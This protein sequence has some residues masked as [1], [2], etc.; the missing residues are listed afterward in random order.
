MVLSKQ[1]RYWGLFFKKT[2]SITIELPVEVVEAVRRAVERGA[3]PSM[4]EAV[5]DAVLH[6][7]PG[8]E[9]TDQ[10][11]SAWQEAMSHS[12]SYLPVD[13]VFSHLEARYSSARKP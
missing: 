12:R 10:L 6:W 13:E 11:R 5:S 9:A 8:D 4:G 2:E 7:A 1:T 3:Y